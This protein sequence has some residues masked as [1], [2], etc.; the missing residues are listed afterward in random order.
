MRI[1]G[2]ITDKKEVVRFFSYL[3][4]EKIE[5]TY[6]LQKEASGEEAYG[7]W[8]ENEDE[9][10]LAK[11]Y[12]LKF[13]ENPQNSDFDAV[14]ISKDVVED[15][16]NIENEKYE[17]IT[18]KQTV[19]FN[20]FKGFSPRGSGPKAPFTK[21]IILLCIAIF[22][23]NYG[24][25]KKDHLPTLY[26]P[27]STAL[28]FDFPK[29]VE[30]YTTF[31]KEGNRGAKKQEEWSA[32][33]KQELKKIDRMPMWQGFY[34][35][36]LYP[37]ASSALLQAP[38]FTKIKE[39]QVWRLLTPVFLHGDFLHILFNMLWLWMLGKQIEIKVGWKRYL[40]LS[41]VIGVISNTCQYLMSGPFFIGYSGIVCG[42]AGFIWMRQ[43]VAP[44]EGYPIPKG[45]IG[46]LAIFVFAMFALQL[47]SFILL[48][49][50]IAN[51][52]INIANTAHLVGGIVGV[53][54]ARIPV[55]YK[56]AV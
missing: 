45:T 31:L 10:A 27:V 4:Q 9:V 40:F 24:V 5:A 50:D 53:I 26:S 32:S 56:G 46:F 11:S 38:M 51:F 36:L 3:Y 14:L 12:L 17:K 20:K 30:V 48:R 23:I 25:S 42:L 22:I 41:L 44:W 33:E 39:G 16:K 1:I 6:D 13:K 2:T 28:L 18:K 29:P 54:A 43:K 55:F 19:S 49:F 21:W 15:Q 47:V 8:I 34:T 7:I 37:S 52:N 35:I